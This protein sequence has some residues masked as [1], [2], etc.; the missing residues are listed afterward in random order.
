[1]EQLTDQSVRYWVCRGRN[2]ECKVINLCYFW[3]QSPLPCPYGR[4]TILS[5][6]LM[7]RL[8]AG[9]VSQFIELPH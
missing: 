7:L 2:Q 4:I 3:S 5:L 9:D 6:Y 1:M 8:E